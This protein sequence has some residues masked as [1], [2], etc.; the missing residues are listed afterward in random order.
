[1]KR[2]LP[3]LV[4]VAFAD[5]SP[6]QTSSASTIASTMQQMSV[7]FG[8]ATASLAAAFFVPDRFRTSPA[9]MMHGIH[10]AFL[11]LGGLTI[12]SALVFRELRN[13]DGDAVSQH[14]VLQH[15]G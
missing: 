13:D 9:E 3:W 8:V 7:S 1:V 10:L 5:V 2:L 14:H 15:D 6:E 11:A 12:L 4:A